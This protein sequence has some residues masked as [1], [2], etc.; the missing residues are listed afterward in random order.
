MKFY[1]PAFIIIFL[2]Y[3]M[4]NIPGVVEFEIMKENVETWRTFGF[5]EFSYPF[6]EVGLMFL[7]ILPFFL[8]LKSN[9][10]LSSF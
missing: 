6:L 1:M 10:S 5:Y 4:I 3:Y 2:F 9:L 7:A 8:L